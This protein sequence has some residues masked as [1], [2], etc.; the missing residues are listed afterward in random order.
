MAQEK[1]EIKEPEGEDVEELEE[2]DELKMSRTEEPEYSVN[3]KKICDKIV[4]DGQGNKIRFGDIYKHQKTVIVFVRVRI[5]G[6]LGIINIFS[7]F[8]S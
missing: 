3:F 7:I 2:V 1:D 4:F 5:S 8:N 6:H